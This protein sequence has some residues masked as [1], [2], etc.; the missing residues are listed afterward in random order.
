MENSLAV[1]YATHYKSTLEHTTETLV[2]RHLGNNAYNNVFLAVKTET[3]SESTTEE[4]VSCIIFLN[5]A[6]LPSNQKEIA[7]D[8]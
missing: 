3:S 6:I 1:P 4:F 5:N 2:H 8:T 7:A